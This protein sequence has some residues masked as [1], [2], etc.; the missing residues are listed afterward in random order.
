[1]YLHHSDGKKKLKNLNAKYITMSWIAQSG[2]FTTEEKFNV[3]I[4][5]H[6]L[7]QQK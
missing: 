1:M 4:L 5:Y 3:E 7:V 6:S 2:N